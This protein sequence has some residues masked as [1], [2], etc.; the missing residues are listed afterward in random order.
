MANETIEM[1]VRKLNRPFYYPVKIFARVGM[2]NA[3]RAMRSC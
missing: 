3:F 1:F 2:T